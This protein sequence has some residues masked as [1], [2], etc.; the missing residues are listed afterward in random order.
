MVESGFGVDFG[1]IIDFSSGVSNFI[2][3]EIEMEKVR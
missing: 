2:N 3:L 1:G